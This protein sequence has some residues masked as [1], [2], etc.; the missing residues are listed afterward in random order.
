VPLLTVYAAAASID[1][2]VTPSASQINVG[3]TVEYVVTATGEDVVAMQFE[4]QVPEGM[5]YIANSGAVPNGLAQKLG[6][7]A[8][9]WTEISHMFTFYNDVGITIHQGTELLRFSCKAEKP[10]TYGITLYELLPFDSNFE[11]FAPEVT[12]LPVKVLASQG[13][14]KPPAT[15]PAATEP[16]A[17]LPP[18]TVPPVTLPPATEPQVTVPGETTPAVQPQATEP[19]M[20]TDP[21]EE[22]VLQEQPAIDETTDVTVQ[23]DDPAET[24]PSQESTDKQQAGQQL[25]TEEKKIPAAVWIIPTVLL[26]IGGGTAAILLL[27]KKKQSGGQN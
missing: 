20:A 4:L 25:P 11:E 15:L 19:V 26:A 3:D 18:A 1:I 17:T 8:A 14:T 6:V 7:P 9:D 2:Q 27:R 21:T 24:V 13:Q 10:G 23:V 5:S 16:P 12:V 22:T